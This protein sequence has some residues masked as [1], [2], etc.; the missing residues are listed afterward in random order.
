MDHDEWLLTYSHPAYG[1]FPLKFK[2]ENNKIIS[3]DIKV[4][5]ELEFDPYTFVKQ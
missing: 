4:N 2:M 1:I 5:D 3:T